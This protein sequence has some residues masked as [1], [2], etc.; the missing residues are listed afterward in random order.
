MSG[1]TNMWDVNTVQ[2]LSG[3]QKETIFTIMDNYGE[4]AKK[5]PD[6]RKRYE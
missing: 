6:V 2:R 5:Y 1:V 3:L 4:L